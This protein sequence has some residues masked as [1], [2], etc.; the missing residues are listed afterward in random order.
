MYVDKPLFDEQECEEMRSGYP[1]C[2]KLLTACYQFPSA[3]TCVPPTLYCER[4]RDRYEATGLNPYDIRK[5]CTGDPGL[6]YDVIDAIVK[7]ANN[8]EVR[9]ELGVDN[10]AGEFYGYP[11]SVNYRFTFSGD[12]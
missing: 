11:K 10:E 1:F 12:G 8:P 6:C 5:K 7:Y 3:I 9:W 2:E 4:I